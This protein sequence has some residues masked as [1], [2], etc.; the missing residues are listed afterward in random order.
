MLL[1][2]PLHSIVIVVWAHGKNHHIQRKPDIEPNMQVQIFTTL[3][4]YMLL[5]SYQCCTCSTACNNRYFNWNPWFQELCLRGSSKNTQYAC[6]WLWPC[7][8]PYSCAPHNTTTLQVFK[9]Q[10]YSWWG[11]EVLDA[12]TVSTIYQTIYFSWLPLVIERKSSNQPVPL[13]CTD[14]LF[15]TGHRLQFIIL[16]IPARWVIPTQTEM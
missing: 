4:V 1:I 15:S 8:G 13:T 12:L 2:S 16:N 10:G 14:M 11:G 3:F 9:L 5:R 7:G 6:T